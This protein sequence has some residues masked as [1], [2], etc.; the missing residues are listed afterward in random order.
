MRLRHIEVFH[1]VMQT[2]TI[3]A[4]SKLLNVSQ[5]AI[6]KILQHAEDRLGFK[7]FERVKGRLVPTAEGRILFGETGRL[8]GSL[9]SVRR[10]A[11]S[12]KEGRSGHIRLAAS[13]ALCID[14]IPLAVARF[15][16]RHP[17]VSFDIET[18]SYGEL[19]AAVASHDVDLGIA[20][21]AQPRPG[22]ALADLASGEFLA[23]LPD[24]GH[25][26][27]PGSIPL[28]ALGAWTFIGLRGDDPLGA[29]F[30]AALERFGPELKPA[31]EVKTNRVA[32]ALAARG[33]GAT[34]VDQYTALAAGP[35]V[36]IRRLDPPVL[37][38]VRA[39]WPVEA[40]PS[41][42]ARRFLTTLEAAER[43][44]AGGLGAATRAAHR[45]K[46]PAVQGSDP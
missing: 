36:R 32:V 42:V 39:L 5:P 9:E 10:V 24:D 46:A 23:V 14:L 26:A 41:V 31:I 8:Y 18:H 35:G 15:R 34:I 21:E 16:E 20:F 43:E 13:P 28:A 3:S 33:A 22:V 6:T 7:L 19:Q 45:S 38:A 2:G 27:P 1:T 40:P 4:A 44:I 11:R 17:E 37:L 29:A 25:P 12:L 30:A